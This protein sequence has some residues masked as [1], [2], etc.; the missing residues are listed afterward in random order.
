M[1]RSVVRRAVGA[2][3]L[4][5]S[6]PSLAW[7][8]PLAFQDK[9][10]TLQQRQEEQEDYFRKWLSEDVVYIIS[11]EERAVFESLGTDDER[12]QFI[13]QFW[14]RRDGDPRTDINEFKI[15]HYRRIAYANEWFRSGKPGW[16]TDRGRIYIV[17]GKPAEVEKHPTGG[18]YQRSIHEGGG[19]TKTV[20]FEVWRYRHI[21][22]IGANV[23]LEFVD[24]SGSG[25]YRLTYNP[26]EKDALIYHL[27]GGPTLAEEMGLAK[28][29]DRPFFSPENRDYPLM[30]QRIEDRPFNRYE[31]Y[32]KALS[33]T[34]I[35]YTDLKQAVSV[36]ISYRDF[37]FR[38]RPDY[39]R[40]NE[41]Q[42]LV[43]IN[44]EI[45][46][47][48]LTF[49][50]ENGRHVARIAVYGAVTS[51]RN[52][53]VAEFDDDL[54]VSFAP[55]ELERGLQGRSVYQ[56]IV[57]VAADM[58]YKLD[59]VVKDAASGKLGHRV[60]SVLPPRYQ[61]GK[62]TASSLV[63]AD[64]LQPLAEVPDQDEMF[65]IGDVKV[66]PRLDRSFTDKRPV[67]LYLHVYNANLDQTT[68]SPALTVDYVLT[69]DGQMVREV[70]DAEG[71]TV[72]FA[73]SI[74]AVLVKAFPTQG[75]EPGEYRLRVDI[76]DRLSG[77]RVSVEEELRLREDPHG[78]LGR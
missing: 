78:N 18:S 9:T 49:Q 54:E 58:R 73:S 32:A 29:Q 16:K 40:L 70:S 14:K 38:I 20:P 47:K 77:Q 37:P 39:F 13:E 33:A 4:S 36:N 3:A 72:Q 8:M 7:S 41:Q 24:P 57:P 21:E 22:G 27:G 25:E 42:V 59:L 52:E 63:L 61:A 30:A 23:I 56:K 60:G 71:K 1:S 6:A 53:L 26:D 67:G 34:P 74:R 75:L 69:R 5:L 35:R 45:D 2:I 17:H 64:W 12:E 66:R 28:R 65:V 15:E 10:E 50:T 44:L 43:P 11:D 48:E 46:N 62:L 76:E 31:R 55:A 19:I 51:I 68:L